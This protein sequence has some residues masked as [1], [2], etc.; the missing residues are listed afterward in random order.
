MRLHIQIILN[1]Q[2]STSLSKDKYPLDVFSSSA[3][4]LQKSSAGYSPS[5]VCCH[6]INGAS[7]HL[8]M[9]HLPLLV[10][11]L[12]F[13]DWSEV[14]TAI[15][16]TSR[17]PFLQRLDSRAVVRNYTKGVRA[18][19]TAGPQRWYPQDYLTASQL[20]DWLWDDPP[21]RST[22]HR[23]HMALPRAP[24]FFFFFSTTAWFRPW[25]HDQ[26]CNTRPHTRHFLIRES[27]FK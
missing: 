7:A 24:G 15:G 3:D 2:G 10:S 25:K 23:V 26:L 11:G 17:F 9:A 27:I 22:P 4:K 13:R 20:R 5:R 1:P 18:S 21:T 6:F 16:V 12:L 8:A 14:S 19:A